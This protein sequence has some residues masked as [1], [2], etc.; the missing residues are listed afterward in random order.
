MAPTSRKVRRAIWWLPDHDAPIGWA[1]ARNPVQAQR[2]LLEFDKL[3]ERAVDEP[4][5]RLLKL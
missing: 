5:L 3:F 2:V 1:E 4:G